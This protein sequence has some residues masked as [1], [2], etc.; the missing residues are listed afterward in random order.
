[1]NEGTV[2][3]RV[4]SLTLGR[5]SAK[6]KKSS[7]SVVAQRTDRHKQFEGETKTI[8]RATEISP[9]FLNEETITRF[10]KK[11]FLKI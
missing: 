10:F 11:N 1:M 7:R 3:R 8:R 6:K 4:A 9:I 5:N 2:L